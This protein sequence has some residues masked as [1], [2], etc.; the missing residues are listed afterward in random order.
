MLLVIPAQAGIHPQVTIKGMD[1][2][3]HGDDALFAQC[4]T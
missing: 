4:I 2:R 1:P 3:L